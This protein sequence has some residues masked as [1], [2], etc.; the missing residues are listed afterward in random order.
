MRTL[1]FQKDRG[2]DK[3]T[4][5]KQMSVM[6]GQILNL[7]QAL[8]DNKTPLQLVQMPCITVELTKLKHDRQ[9]SSSCSAPQ[10][11]VTSNSGHHHPHTMQHQS[12]AAATSSYHRE[13]LDSDFHF[14]QSVS[15]RAPI[16]SCWQPTPSSTPSPPS[17]NPTTLS[18]HL[19]KSDRHQYVSFSL[20]FFL[21]SFPKDA[22]VL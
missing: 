13:R 21:S 11:P 15:S 2:F 1:E 17:R 20:Y 19:Y 18:S 5:E 22:F 14:K 8:K 3:S 4:F 9:L 10:T 6:R 12:A 16:F 7:V